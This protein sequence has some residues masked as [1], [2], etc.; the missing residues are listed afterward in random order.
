MHSDIEER[1]LTMAQAIVRKID[2]DPS[3]GGLARARSICRRWFESNPVP[4]NREWLEILE[5]PWEEVR[6]VLLD[7][8]ENGRRLRQNDPFCGI[9]TNEER[10]AIYRHYREKK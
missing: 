2:A 4:A 1:S 8:S 7:K 5:R 9:L 3:R 10:W 6:Q